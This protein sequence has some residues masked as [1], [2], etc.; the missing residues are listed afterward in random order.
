MINSGKF[1]LRTLYLRLFT[2]LLFSNLAWQQTVN[3]EEALSP[4]LVVSQ[5]MDALQAN[6]AERIRAS[7]SVDA[8]Q[9]YERWWAREK[10]GDSFRAWLE[11]DIISTH[12][13]VQN[14]NISADENRVV[15]TGEFENNSGYSAPADFLFE[16][17]G[18]KII[19][20]TIRY[21]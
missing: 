1:S 7:F 16:I 8:T 12:G 4:K 6:D 11:S 21:D 19:S 2:L 10:S 18:N 9:L 15:V 14:A 5:L 20:W 3:A 17:E 13:K